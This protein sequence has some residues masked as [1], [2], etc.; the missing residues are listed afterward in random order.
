MAKIQG[1][2]VP[3]LSDSEDMG[4]FIESFELGAIELADD[5]RLLYQHEFTEL[6]GRTS[7]G[8]LEIELRADGVYFSAD[9]PNEFRGESVAELVGRGDLR[10]CSF[11]MRVLEQNWDYSADPFRRTIRRA[12]IGEI[13]IVCSPAY[14]ATWV[15]VVE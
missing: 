6:L 2:A 8:T 7:S 14:P 1:L 4:G 10:G 15:E 3:Y 5:V 11:A 12:V 9:L 13:S